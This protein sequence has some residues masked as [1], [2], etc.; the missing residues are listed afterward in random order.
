[1]VELDI[2]IPVY[3]NYQYTMGCL[4][5]IFKSRY[6][7]DKLHI[8]VVDNASTDRT[9]TFM[10]YLVDE[11]E[12]ITYLRQET[13][14][15]YVKGL[16]AGLKASTAPFI[17]SLNND[18]ILDKNCIPAMMKVLQENEKIGIAGALE[19]F[20]NGLPTKDK[21]FIYW[22]PKTILD[23]VL[24]GVSDVHDQIER[25]QDYVDVDLVGS[26]CCIYKKEVFEKIGVFDETF[27]MGMY[28]Q[29]DLE[30]RAQKAGFK[31]AMCLDAMFVHYIAR[32]TSFNQ[33]YY[34]KLIKINKAL[35]LHKW[36]K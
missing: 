19:F 11:G 35:F 4:A 18:T 7:K 8:F 29:E 23:P 1:M 14:L 9:N 13:N 32:T 21:P 28:E 15:G 22:K 31:I 20:P 33:D 3:N 12:P 36:V 27:G 25:G 16:N 34:Q 26:A 6:P 24:K 5:S 17:M 10:S 30:Y 2:I